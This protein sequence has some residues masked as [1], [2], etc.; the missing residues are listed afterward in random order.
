MRRTLSTCRACSRCR[1][2]V[3]RPAEQSPSRDVCKLVVICKV[4]LSLLNAPAGLKAAPLSGDAARAEVPRGEPPPAPV[5]KGLQELP[6]RLFACK[7]DNL[8]GDLSQH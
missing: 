4:V 1:V 5:W 3:Q 6:V 8:T 2:V 7:R